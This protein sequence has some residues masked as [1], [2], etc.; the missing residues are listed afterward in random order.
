VKRYTNLN[1]K[2]LWTRHPEM[3]HKALDARINDMLE[4]LK[5]IA[6]IWM[7]VKKKK[8]KDAEPSTL[9][10][11]A[12]NPSGGAAAGPS[13]SRHVDP[14]GK[15]KE[16]V[17]DKAAQSKVR[18]WYDEVSVLTGHGESEGAHIFSVSARG[19]HT[20]LFELLEH[21][22]DEKKI[23]AWLN[24]LTSKKGK[25]L[26]ILPM[27]AT[28]H[29]ISDIFSFAIRPIRCPLEPA[30]NPKRMYLQLDE[31]LAV[32]PRPPFKRH[33]ARRRNLRFL[34]D[35]R[36]EIAGGEGPAYLRHGQILE[37]VTPDPVRMPLPSFEILE[38]TYAL[39]RIV[40]ALRAAGFLELLFGRDPPDVDPISV[41]RAAGTP[42]PKFQEWLIEAAV[43]ARV[44]KPDQAPKW[45]DVARVQEAEVR[46]EKDREEHELLVAAGLAVPAP[47]EKGSKSRETSRQQT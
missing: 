27:E 36:D 4:D 41:Q 16:E 26:N 40:G 14:D 9:T 19:R 12:P 34:S 37:L 39:T 46:A 32:H 42:L 45:R 43:Y 24:A 28:A 29:K 2:N 3:F 18:R 7:E 13:S 21:F 33:D 23:E 20:E 25:L 5:G 38:V 10:A 31:K 11:K 8:K 35:Y 6:S 17:Q 47:F 30:K 1:V 22:W 44:I 15:S